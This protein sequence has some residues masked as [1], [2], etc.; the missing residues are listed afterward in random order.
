MEE[1]AR[2]HAVNSRWG[3]GDSRKGRRPKLCTTSVLH[4]AR[5]LELISWILDGL[6]TIFLPQW[7]TSVPPLYIVRTWSPSV[8]LIT[9][10]RDQPGR[11]HATEQL[12][13]LLPSHCRSSWHLP[14][15]SCRTKKKKRISGWGKAVMYSH[16]PHAVIP[17]C[18][19]LIKSSIRSP[20]RAEVDPLLPSPLESIFLP[21][22]PLGH[23][24]YPHSLSL[25]G[26]YQTGSLSLGMYS[27]HLHPTY[28]RITIR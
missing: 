25:P 24:E 28:M 13:K 16:L 11:A 10:S 27:P 5:C 7:E 19:P 9:H 8:T 3:W 12:W 6:G 22:C 23:A 20:G 26:P 18:H 15:L 14:W 2:A 17:L 21:C 4:G 1:L